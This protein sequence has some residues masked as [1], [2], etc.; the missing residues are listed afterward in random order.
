MSYKYNG[1]T[2]SWIHIPDEHPIIAVQQ[3]TTLTDECINRIADAVVR[4]L[5]EMEG[6]KDERKV[7]HR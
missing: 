3:P 6:A 1:Y 2:D 7:W 4:K 5:R